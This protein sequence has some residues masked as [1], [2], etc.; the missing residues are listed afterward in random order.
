MT[1]D[2]RRV[3]AALCTMACL[4][5]C[6]ASH[7]QAR[8]VA[9][10]VGVGD[11]PAFGKAGALEGPLN[12]VAAMKATLVRRLD[13]AEA[14]IRTLTDARATRFNILAELRALKERSSAGD[15]IVV[16]FSG[17][18][19]SRLDVD[20]GKSYTAALP[21]STGAFLTYEFSAEQP[22]DGMIVGRTDIQPIV[23]ELEAAG[24]SLWVIS[25][26]C[27]SGQQVR[28]FAAVDPS[29][30]PGRFIPAKFSTSGSQILQAVGGRVAPPPYPY[31]DTVFFAAAAEGEVAADIPV[32]FLSKYPTLDGKPHGAFTDALLRVLEG[33]LF[34]DFDGNGT[35]DYAEVQSA[36]TQFA[37]E[38]G[39][40]Q[41]P[42]RLPTLSEDIRQLAARPL[43][44]VAA[45]AR[46]KQIASA[47]LSLGL[48]PAIAPALVQQLRA[49]NDIE[50]VDAG[51]AK[52]D[53][54]LVES[55]T[56]PDQL[57]L[58][59]ASGDLVTRVTKS[60]AAQA[61]PG[62]ARQFAW[63]KRLRTTGEAGRRGL[64]NVEIAPSQFG[65]N[66]LLNDRL[67][68][69]VRP[70]QAAS[71]LLVNIDSQGMV[72]VLYPANAQEAGALRAGAAHV[73]PEV[74]VGEPFGMDMQLY[75]AFD[76][77][78]AELR[79][80]TGL[81]RMPADDARLRTVDALLAKAAGKYTMAMTELRTLPGTKP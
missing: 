73:L 43:L 64:L 26:S 62:L 28:S 63:A 5:I 44:K 65:G 40:G 48:S 25:D 27:F 16:Y 58:Q 4:L 19:T 15:H 17:H 80:L 12:D 53:L 66:F 22:V 41:A 70:D 79:A 77:P 21:Y 10:L 81:A 75:F 78:F 23:R 35:L 60:A 6:G 59:T 50:V 54:R 38:R 2:L 39:Y 67:H 37:S 13:V 72:S 74:R 11:Y 7:A 52:A 76:E 51:D 47:R 49:V 1:T 8:R 30:L 61:L 68:M 32:R 33:Q 69:V 29:R 36:I 31:R 9:L 18:G 14:D 46:G 57:L 3:A 45:G 55:K 42:Q 34:A 56:N 20:P 24:R 71:V